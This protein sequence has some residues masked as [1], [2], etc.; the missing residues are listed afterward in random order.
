[1]AAALQ[2]SSGLV[3]R[4][5]ASSS[6][7]QEHERQI[8]AAWT[9]YQDRFEGIDRALS[10]VFQQMDA[11]L[12]RYCEQVQKFADEL[13]KTTANCVQRLASATTQLDQSIEDLVES[14]PRTGR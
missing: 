12:S 8:A 3:A 13:D 4:L 2:L 11:G 9:R 14:L 5:E 6:A 1:M 7:F 10:E